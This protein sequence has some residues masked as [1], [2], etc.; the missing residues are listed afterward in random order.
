MLGAFFLSCDANCDAGDTD[1]DGKPN[2]KDADDDNDGVDTKQEIADAKAAGKS[3]DVDGD[4][5]KNWLD[6]DADGDGISDGAERGDANGN[7]VPDYLE[8]PGAI[9]QGA[10]SLVGGTLE[11]GGLDCA[12]SPQNTGSILA[13]VGALLGMCV[14]ARRR[15]SAHRA[16]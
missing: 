11:G 9:D 10:G 16:I 14:T 7:G 8:K 5:K 2:Y 3:E 4:G 13:A 15:S 6:T 12:A 1:K